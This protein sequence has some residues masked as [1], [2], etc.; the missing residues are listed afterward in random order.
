[1]LVCNPCLSNFTSIKGLLYFT[2]FNKK[3][4]YSI[5]KHL[6][7]WPFLFCLLKYTLT[8]IYGARIRTIKNPSMM[9]ISACRYINNSTEVNI[10][11]DYVDVHDMIKW[12]LKY[13]HNSFAILRCMHLKKLHMQ[14]IHMYTGVSGLIHYV[15]YVFY[16]GPLSPGRGSRERGG[17]RPLVYLSPRLMRVHFFNVCRHF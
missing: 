15:E 12:S 4:I 10:D 1:M 3:R 9:K 14:L 7:L 17:S 5:L 13:F 16:C 6:T 8:H 11:V 2:Y